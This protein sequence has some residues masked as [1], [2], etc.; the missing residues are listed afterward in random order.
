MDQENG[1]NTGGKS[2]PNVDIELNIAKACRISA[3]K[4]H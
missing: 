4:A 1:A 2:R 3:S